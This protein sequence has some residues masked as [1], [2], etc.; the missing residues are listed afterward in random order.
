MGGVLG[1][2]PD[3]TT[4]AW[5]QTMTESNQFSLMRQRRFAP[6]FFTQFLGAFNDN[7]FKYAF[8][9]LLAF[10]L[11]ADAELSSDTLINL[12]ALLFILPFFLFSATAGQI[13]DKYE[14]STLIRWVK[15][16]EIL[17]MSLAAVA[18]YFDI[19]WGLMGLLFLMGTQ[20]TV[21]GPLKFG[22]LPQ[23]LSDRELMGGN[24][25]IEMG[26]FLAIL[27]GTMLG[28][29]LVG[30]EAGSLLVSVTIIGA[31]LLGYYVSRFIPRAEPVAP[32]LVVKKNPVTESWHI[33]QLVR[34][35]RTV[36][37]SIL[38]IS[39]FW[40]YG[41]TYLAQLPNYTKITL[42]GNEQVVTILLAVF[43]L[44]IG[45]GSLLCER[46]SGQR[47][48]LGLV[49]F[50]S[51][52]LTLFGIDLYLANLAFTPAS[53]PGA[54][55]FLS[56]QG[57]TRILLDLFLLGL[58][59][60]FF[61]V[62]L[63]A[64]VQQR[65]RRSHLSRIIAGNN[66]LNALFMVL[67]AGLA[68][69][70][71]SYGLSI[72]E[73]LLLTSVLNAFVAVYIYTLVPEFLM[74]FII[75]ILISTIYRVKKEALDQIPDEGPAVL[76]CNHVSFVDALLIGGTVRRPVRFVMY[77]KIFQIPIL[78][79]VF[80]TAKAIP[81]A[82]SKE[83]PEMLE[84]AY[85]K[86][87]QELSEGHL[88]CIFPEGVLT[89]DGEV[90]TFKKGI[91]RIIAR[92]PVPVIPMALRGLWGSLFSRKDDNGLSSFPWRLWSRVALVV[93]PPVAP[94]EASAETLQA[95]V[96]ALRGEWR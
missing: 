76:V 58:F 37:L 85:D 16:F 36:F 73:L 64:L 44:G 19:R 38:G 20:S 82:S 25:L 52:G 70:L 53:V 93:G 81:I 45:S 24:G 9:V 40:F 14:K 7:V 55:A 77:Y 87:A 51:I 65:S 71:L 91:E 54:S 57:S 35:N 56:A 18:F 6:L 50:G 95:A 88:V 2:I 59:G 47:V 3:T 32:D 42:A 27:L 28:G 69:V 43:I 63:Y 62:P 13:A 94:E 4:N 49:P 66:I 75:W 34:E 17:I 68:I 29:I 21:F 23:H 33:F 90:N 80:K 26:T 79:F 96:S 5:N 12:A 48:E 41:G 1:I 84:E 74:R 8:S 83:D 31:S 86:V 60:G 22:I 30:F 89:D 61:I 78:R 11:A 67:S 92:T 10:R 72:P 46:L 15:L 39:W